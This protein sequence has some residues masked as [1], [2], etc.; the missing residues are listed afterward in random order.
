MKLASRSM[1]VNSGLI[2]RPFSSAACPLSGHRRLQRGDA[3]FD[4]LDLNG[5]GRVIEDCFCHPY[6]PN[7]AVVAGRFA[8]S[9]ARFSAAG[10]A[11]PKPTGGTTKPAN[12]EGAYNADKHCCSA[13]VSFELQQA[14]LR[15]AAQRPILSQ[16]GEVPHSFRTVRNGASHPARL[17]C[18]C[19][20]R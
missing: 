11:A 15:H 8:H 2:V 14:L 9:A 19:M 4:I 20:F 16:R 7:G 12:T 5:L 18:V 13:N 6:R 1:R 10:S 17:V 3:R